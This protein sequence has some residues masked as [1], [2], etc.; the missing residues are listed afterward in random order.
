MTDA[1]RGASLRHNAYRKKCQ[2][3]KMSDGSF[4]SAASRLREKA[5]SAA[6]PATSWRPEVGDELIGRLVRVDTRPTKQ[7]AAERV[8]ILEREDGSHLAAWMFY[9]VL[10]DEWDQ[11]DPQPGELVLLKRL[12]DGI[13]KAH[14]GA[15]RR[16]RVT[17]DRAEPPGDWVLA[18]GGA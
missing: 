1:L 2:H 3:D 6:H 17:V 7:S 12:P 14:G 4:E 16:Y 9:R 5:Q 8:A 11:A 10:A 18:E 15:F 13:A